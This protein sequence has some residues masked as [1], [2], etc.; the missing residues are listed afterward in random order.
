[1]N[2]VWHANIHFIFADTASDADI[3]IKYGRPSSWAQT[4]ATAISGIFQKVNIVIDDWA[5]YSYPFDAATQTNIVAHELGHALG[6][7]EISEAD[8]ANAG[9][10][11]IMVNSVYPPSAHYSPYPTEFDKTNI[12]SLY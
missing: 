8:A 10:F 3:V 12:F 11:S 2:D 1:L 6:L 7:A 9:F 4:Y 5:F